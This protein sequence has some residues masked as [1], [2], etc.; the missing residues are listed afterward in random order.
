MEAAF[1][2][3]I[4]GLLIG[5]ASG[6]ELAK[7]APLRSLVMAVFAPLFFATAG[8]RV[9]LTVLRDPVMALVAVGALLVAV[10][11]K[12]AG[13]FLGGL[14]SRLSTMESL[15]LGA[16]MNARGVIQIIVATVGLRVH[17]LTTGTYTVVILVAI[18]TSIMASPILRFAVKRIEQ[19]KEEELRRVALAGF[20]GVPSSAEA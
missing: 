17:V 6:V 18:A 5:S 3:F 10:V 16:G 7:L 12:F 15:A 4:M 2:A 8:L 13:A 1:G 20:R 9:D 14:S 11:G 19:T